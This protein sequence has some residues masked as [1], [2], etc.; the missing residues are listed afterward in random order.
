[1]LGL[2]DFVT[3]LKPKLDASEEDNS[4][5][6]IAKIQKMGKENSESNDDQTVSLRYHS[7]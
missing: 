2:I 5:N 4:T 3:I 7:W 1:M 6:V